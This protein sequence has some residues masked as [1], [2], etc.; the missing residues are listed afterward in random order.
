MLDDGEVELLWTYKPGSEDYSKNHIDHALAIVP[1]TND[2][3]ASSV[4]PAQQEAADLFNS[5]SRMADLPYSTEAFSLYNED[6]MAL[7]KELVKSVVVDGVDIDTA[8]ANFE[9][10]NGV[11]MSQAICDSLNAE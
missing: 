2:P 5:N 3:G 8:Y 4:S 11:K 6:L 9:A 7:K 10:A 1:L